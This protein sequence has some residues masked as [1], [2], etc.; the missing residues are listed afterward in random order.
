MNVQTY[1]VQE[2]NTRELQT[3]DG[4]NLWQGALGRMV[5]SASAMLN[6]VVGFSEGFSVEPY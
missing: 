2:L 3:T 4:G 1:G 5:A 6:F